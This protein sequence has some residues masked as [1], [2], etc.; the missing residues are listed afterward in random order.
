MRTN[1]MFITVVLILLVAHVGSLA[2]VCFSSRGLRLLLALNATC[3]VA[4]LL[5]L[6]SRAPY[7]IAA[8]DWLQLGLFL[9][10]IAVLFAAI[11]AYRDSRIA[12]IGS[13]VAFGL[14]ACASLAAVV[15]A[16]TFKIT[17]LI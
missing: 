7:L 8:K 2:G 4:I 14:H 9:S 5:Y 12:V 16:F 17:K 3:A 15:F 1:T 10:E 6:V 11:L 13:Y